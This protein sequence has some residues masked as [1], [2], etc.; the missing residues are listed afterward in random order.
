VLRSKKRSIVVAMSE[1]YRYTPEEAAAGRDRIVAAFREA[2]GREL[3]KDPKWK[4]AVMMVAQFWADNADDAVHCAFVLS[5]EAVPNANDAERSWDDGD[6]EPSAANVARY[7]WDLTGYDT[8]DEN[9]DAIALFAAF[10]K[11]SCH[12]EMSIAEAYLP[13]ALFRHAPSGGVEVEVVGKK[14]RPWLDGV[15]P[16]WDR[17]EPVPELPPH[18]GPLWV[19]VTDIV[20]DFTVTLEPGDIALPSAG[21]PLVMRVS[22]P[23]ASA[24]AVD[25]FEARR[26]PVTVHIGAD[27]LVGRVRRWPS[28]SWMEIPERGLRSAR[29]I[30]EM[31][32]DATLHDDLVRCQQQLDPTVPED[33]SALVRIDAELGRL[34]HR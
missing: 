7:S 5:T 14:T 33:Q 32:D 27:Q 3:D 2:I 19:V 20:D 10:T 4:S 31:S 28:E 29:L 26:R 24:D 30:A 22:C 6:D 18:A 9:G 11:E 23:P 1:T 15:R 12:Q 17:S 21:R 8:W 34:G 13:Y 16:S 25:R